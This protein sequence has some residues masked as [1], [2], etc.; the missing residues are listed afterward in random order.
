[1]HCVDAYITSASCK[2]STGS[3]PSILEPEQCLKT[4][5]KLPLDTCTLISFIPTR[6]LAYSLPRLREDLHC[7]TKAGVTT[8]KVVLQE[9][10]RG[11]GFAIIVAII[12]T[13]SE[14]QSVHQPALSTHCVLLP[15]PISSAKRPPNGSSSDISR[16]RF[17]RINLKRVKMSRSVYHP[18]CTKNLMVLQR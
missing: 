16:S 18:C 5:P 7:V 3:M 10:P 17:T 14:L 11:G 2:Y 4:F 15:N 1:M 6:R 12:M 13:V 8:I 9:A